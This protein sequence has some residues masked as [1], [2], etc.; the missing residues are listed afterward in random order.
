MGPLLRRMYRGKRTGYLALPLANITPTTIARHNAFDVE[1]MVAC[2]ACDAWIFEPWEPYVRYTIA[3]RLRIHKDIL[4]DEPFS[5]IKNEFLEYQLE[6]GG[7]KTKNRLYDVA[8]SFVNHPKMSN[9]QKT[10]AKI[11][12]STLDDIQFNTLV[13]PFHWI[14]LAVAQTENDPTF[15]MS[16]YLTEIIKQKTTLC[17]MLSTS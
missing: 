13:Q 17:S 11:I 6:G 7:F 12:L 1:F 14:R 5:N 16:L 3:K 10:V 15:S 9:K 2:L 8:S 4:F